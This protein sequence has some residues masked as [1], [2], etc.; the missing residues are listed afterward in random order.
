MND[1]TLEHPWSG[2][3][4]WDSGRQRRR[5]ELRQPLPRFP[6]LPCPQRN[7]H[8]RRRRHPPPD[9]KHTTRNLWW[10]D[11]L[12]GRR[13]ARPGAGAPLPPNGHPGHYAPQPPQPLAG[14]GAGP[15][16]AAHAA[17]PTGHRPPDRGPCVDERGKRE[18]CPCRS[19][20]RP[21]SPKFC[22]L[23]GVTHSPEDFMLKFS[24]CD[25]N[26]KSFVKKK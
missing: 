1:G 3:H 9:P 26:G 6:L 25:R 8:L 5:P 18:L 22:P 7:P 23:E 20:A 2:Q 12:G 4:A 17:G 21:H 15:G 24:D 13:A 16:R 10:P 19:S 14:G 11:R